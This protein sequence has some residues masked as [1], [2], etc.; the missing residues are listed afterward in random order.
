MICL[1][2]TQY[3]KKILQ[4]FGANGKTKPVSTH[5]APYFKLIASLSPYTKGEH[6]HIAQ[7]LYTNIVGALMYATICPRLKFHMLSI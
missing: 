2:R 1:T 4:R 7:I 6:K 3:L 5:L